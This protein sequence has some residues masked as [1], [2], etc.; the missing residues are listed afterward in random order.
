MERQVKLARHD[1]GGFYDL[2]REV[3]RPYVVW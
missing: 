1:K 2:C 3:E